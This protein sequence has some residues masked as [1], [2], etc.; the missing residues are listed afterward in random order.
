MLIVAVLRRTKVTKNSTAQATAETTDQINSPWWWKNCPCFNFCDHITA[1][2]SSTF[3]RLNPD[4]GVWSLAKRALANS[5][6]NDVEELV[7]DIIRSINRSRISTRKLRGCILQS[8]L[9]FF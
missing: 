4:E 6:P 5:C 2:T 1:C 8:G 3:P 7:E 9:P